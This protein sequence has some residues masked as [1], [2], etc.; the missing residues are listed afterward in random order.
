VVRVLPFQWILLFLTLCLLS[1]SPVYGQT[2]IVQ[3]TDAHSTL[4]TLSQQIFAIDQAG[5]EFLRQHPRGEFVVYVIGDFTSIN[6]Y[7]TEERGWL[8]F[9]ALHLLKQR[10]YTVLFTPGNHDA[11]DWTA[12]INGAELFL[13][14][15]RQLKAWDIPVL[16]ANLKPSL[17]LAPLIQ[18]AYP[19][20]AMPM[21][22]EIVGLTLP[23]LMARSNL[24]ETTARLVFDSIDPLPET[25]R[26]LI[27]ELVE[28]GVEKVIF[29][30]HLGHKKLAGQVGVINQLIRQSESDLRV[31]LMLGAHDHLAASY[32]QR[33]THIADAASHGSFNIIDFDTAG[34]L[35]RNQIQHVAISE[36][37]LAEIKSSLWRVGAARVN[38][39]TVD[40]TRQ[41]PWLSD[42][43]SRVQNHMQEVQRR[44][45][46]SLVTL[47]HGILEHK[48]DLKEGPGLL[49]R[50]MGEAL[51]AWARQHRPAQSPHPIVAMANSSSYRLESR[52]PAGPVT[53][54]DVRSIYPFLAE[55]AL[56]LLDGEQIQD[57]YL[58]L[59]IRYMADN[60]GTAYSPHLN[61]EVRE[62][63]GALEII[64]A[65]NRWQLVSPDQR[66]W[67]AVD[68]WLAEHRLGQSYRI[69]E[70]I[71]ILSNVRP[72][73]V[74]S[75]QE[76]L[77]RHLPDVF[78]RHE[79]GF[80]DQ[81]SRVLCRWVFAP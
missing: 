74:E 25:W 62:R 29:G 66:Y 58:S 34:R 2:R 56:F 31:P 17:E 16:V 50:M 48:M 51:V 27:P 14:Q 78:A 46:R 38:S 49:G 13:E 4:A 75:Y 69:P 45:G 36:E 10:G 70:W 40:D 67:L 28:R 59:R 60:G 8:S 71:D 1:F 7:N 22:T 53:E 33:G 73:H 43:E 39:T 54:F 20:R 80:A 18:D 32:R 41:S 24:N 37:K 26:G 55:S 9:E 21:P 5:Q 35:R 15:M 79:G 44:L 61:F 42:F 11:F 72:Y 3:W 77:V 30:A 52:L 65:N 63:N 6:P 64:G 12:R 19:L 81:T 57:L 76:L 23:Q 68:G 47:D